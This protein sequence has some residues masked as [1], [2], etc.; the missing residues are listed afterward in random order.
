MVYTI[1]VH[2]QAKPVRQL[3]S[4]S[5]AR[6][7]SL[8]RPERVRLTGL[9][10][11]VE[12]QVDRGFSILPKRRGDH[13]LVRHAGPQGEFW[14][15]GPSRDIPLLLTLF[16]FFNRTRPSSVLSSDTRKNRLKLSTQARNTGVTLTLTS[17]LCLPFPW[18]SGDTRRCNSPRSVLS[19]KHTVSRS[20]Q[21]LAE[22]RP[23]RSSH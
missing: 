16:D 3:S 23:I 18:T 13:R 14:F 10:P 12:G 8:T 9:R 4:T 5:R 20:Y 7:R 6:I 11:E 17:F 22:P 19:M 21:V 1:I 15:T 2:M